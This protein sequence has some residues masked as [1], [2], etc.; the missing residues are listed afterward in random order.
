MYTYRY[1]FNDLLLHLDSTGAGLQSLFGVRFGAPADESRRSK[2]VQ[3]YMPTSVNDS[4]AVIE[5]W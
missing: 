4:E 3:G 5:S 1:F 2:V